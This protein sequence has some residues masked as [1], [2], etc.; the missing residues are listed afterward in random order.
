MEAIEE[1][2]TL[3][4]SVSNHREEREEIGERIIFMRKIWQVKK[5]QCPHLAAKAE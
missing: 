1:K 3:V 2:T 4:M 5:E